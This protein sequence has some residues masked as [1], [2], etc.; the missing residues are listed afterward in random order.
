MPEKQNVSVS[1]ELLLCELTFNTINHIEDLYC[2][3]LSIHNYDRFETSGV[4]QQCI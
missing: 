2:S 4:R 3:N 1:R